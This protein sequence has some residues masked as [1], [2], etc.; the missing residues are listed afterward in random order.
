LKHSVDTLA[1]NEPPASTRA[2]QDA[3]KAF[4]DL[5][6]AIVVDSIAHLWTT[7]CTLVLA[8]VST[9]VVV[10]I[11]VSWETSCVALAVGTTAVRKGWRWARIVARTTVK[12]RIGGVLFASIRDV[13]VAILVTLVTSQYA[14]IHLAH[15]VAVQCRTGLIAIA[16][17]IQGTRYGNTSTHGTT[18]LVTLVTGIYAT[19]VGHARWSRFVGPGITSDATLQTIGHGGRVGLASVALCIPIAILPTVVALNDTLTRYA[20]AA[21]RVLARTGTVASTAVIEVGCDIHVD[22]L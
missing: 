21:N 14:S 13:V 16:T 7:W 19:H 17:V 10:E 4:V 12:S 8:T 1:R 6:V 2:T 20:S 22:A 5:T 15:R 3:S 11:V 9:H 18:V